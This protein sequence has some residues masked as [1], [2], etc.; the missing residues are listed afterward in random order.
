[1]FGLILVFVLAN[2]NYTTSK[3]FLFPS[4]ASCEH[5]LSIAETYQRGVHSTDGVKLVGFCIPAE[6]DKPDATS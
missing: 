5:E 4:E 3:V 2:G 6:V 1:M